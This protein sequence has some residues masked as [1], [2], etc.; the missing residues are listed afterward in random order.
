[1]T[2]RK[3]IAIEVTKATPSPV[4]LD[5]QSSVPAKELVMNLA[6][7]SI[8]GFAESPSLAECGPSSFGR[9]SSLLINPG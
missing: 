1:M 3:D 7:H 2:R 5:D 4:N 9:N 8:L 6:S